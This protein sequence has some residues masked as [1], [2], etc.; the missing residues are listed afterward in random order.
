MTPVLISSTGNGR[1]KV[2]TPGIVLSLP[3]ISAVT[4]AIGLRSSGGLIN[5]NVMPW[6]DARNPVAPVIVKS[7]MTFGSLCNISSTRS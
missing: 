7:V 4:S 1:R 3:I 2:I 5:V 6:F